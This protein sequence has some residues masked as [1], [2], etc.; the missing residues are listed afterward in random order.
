[1]TDQR[2][3]SVAILGAG[4]IGAA[5]ARNTTKAG[6]E[7]AVWNRSPEKL[8]P[9]IEAGIPTVNDAAEAVAGQDVVLSVLS[10]ADATLEVVGPLLADLKAGAIW[11][12]C[13]TIGIEGCDRVIAAAAEAGVPLVDAP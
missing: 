7:T 8:G 2:A 9:L 13:A 11:L 5:M 3:Q 4:I 1:M 10:D 6:I 12:Q